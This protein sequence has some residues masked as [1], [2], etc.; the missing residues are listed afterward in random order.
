MLLIV[1]TT[2]IFLTASLLFAVQPMF[3]RMV[4]PLLG[5]SP[6]VWNTARVFY[7]AVLL[8]G[9]GYAHLTTRLL[10]WRR[11]ALLHVVVLL[12][13]FAVLPIAVPRGWATAATANPIPW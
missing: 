8:L 11:Q 13:P 12:V 6:S 10:G 3:A 1:Y 7:Q 5:G 2:T 4:L 9:Y